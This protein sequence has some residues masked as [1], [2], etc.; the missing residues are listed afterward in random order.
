MT[1]RR[2]RV[3]PTTRRERRAS[4]RLF[5][6]MADDGIEAARQAVPFVRD[7]LASKSLY[8][9]I[10]DV[11]SRM[12]LRHPDAL[13]LRYTR[14]MMGFLMF[15][16]APRDIAMVGLGGGSLAKFCLRYLPA[17]RID[18]VE[19][20]PRV[21]ALRDE[22]Q[23]PPDNERF[24]VIEGDGAAFMQSAVVRYDVVMLDA[25][26]P[27]G[28]PRPLS[29]QRFYDDCVDALQPG[30]VLV[31]NFHS[32]A[33]DFD[34]C[35]ERIDRSFSGGALV[36]EDVEAGNNIVFARKGGAAL[37]GSL[38]AGLAAR[39]RGLEKAAW[40]QLSGAFERIASAIARQVD[41]GSAGESEAIGSAW[42]R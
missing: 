17:A 23:V 38:R 33:H 39:P 7:G 34:A 14:T 12:Q 13:D 28:L 36:I 40:T 31:S 24:H 8:F 29:A 16:P 6:G 19:I 18:V 41:D 4:D 30:G 37:A 35:V 2:F 21:I 27:Q 11:Q 10:E 5:S 20:N 25:F 22:F 26:G 9:S 32:A 1:A 3:F 15:E 42:K